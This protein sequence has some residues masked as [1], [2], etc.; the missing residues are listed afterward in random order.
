MDSSKPDQASQPPESGDTAMSPI[1]HTQSQSQPQQKKEKKPKAAKQ[2]S[3][4]PALPLSPALIDFRVGHILRC[5]P[6]ENAD[7]LYVS[8]IAMGDPEGTENTHKDEET[9]RVV[10]T[11]CSG[12]RGLIPLE[13]MQDRKVIVMANLKPV[14]MR[15][16]KSAAMVL[17]ASPPPKEGE[18]PHTAD[19]VV[20]LVSP[21]EGSEGGN[22]VYFEGWEYGEGC[23]PE[24][25]LNPKKK[26]WESL[27][28]GLYT[29]EDLTVVFDA[30]RVHGVEGGKGELVV[31]GG[32]GKCK[33]TSLKGARLS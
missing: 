27:Q 22:R 13:Q 23:G 24:T 20:E 4:S 33:V 31:E 14:T 32:K 19:R 7:S 12:L 10:R 5:T 2:P 26:Q 29:S 18:D 8:T 28:P 25:V 3:A 15:G 9:G 16:I 17:A 21:P 11:V 1:P 30:G 6:H